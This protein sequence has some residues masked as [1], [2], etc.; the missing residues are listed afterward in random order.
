[1]AL[2]ERW[3]NE[4]AHLTRPGRPLVTLSYAQGLDGSIAARRGQPSTI[5]GAESQRVT[6]QLRV[7][8]DAILVGIGTILSDDPQL[9]VRLVEGPSPRPVILDGSLRTPPDSKAL[10][11]QPII[12]CNADAGE[13][14]Q[15]A[16]EAAGAQVERQPQSGR[17]DLDAMLARLF[18]LG[19]RSLMVEGGGEVIESVV[20]EGLADRAML[21]IAPVNLRGYTIRG[22]LPLLKS[23]QTEDAGVDMLLFGRLEREAA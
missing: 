15:A 6:H 12:F 19:V 16:L 13:Q 9:N 7:A 20:A 5:S 11:G 4:T 18:A 8:H 17:I 3:L 23:M 14:A 2:L 10:A 1:M 21:T 22:V